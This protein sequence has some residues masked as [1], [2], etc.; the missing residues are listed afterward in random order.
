MD[1]KNTNIPQTP[2]AADSTPDEDIG[3]FLDSV[4][5]E[6]SADDFLNQLYAD[7]FKDLTSDFDSLLKEYQSIDPDDLTGQHPASEEKAEPVQE[8][9]DIYSY[10]DR[11]EAETHRKFSESVQQAMEAEQAEAER[12]EAQAD[13][14]NLSIDML[15]DSQADFAQAVEQA[16]A[17]EQ[18]QHTQIYSAGA[19][20]EAAKDKPQQGRPQQSRPQQGRPQQN[21]P[22]QNRPQQGKPQNGKKPAKANAQKQKKNG[23]KRSLFPQKNDSTFEIFRKV[24]FLV[25]LVVVVVCIGIIGNTYLLQPY[26]EKGRA[27]RI[28]DLLK[29]DD[30]SDEASFRAAYGNTSLPTGMRYDLAKFYAENNDFYGYLEIPGTGVSTPVVQGKD[31][32]EYLRKNFFGETTKYGCPF[33]NV[34]NTYAALDDNTSIFGHNMEYDDLVF[35]ELEKYREIEGF[36]KA[37]V[38]HLETMYADYTFKIY[39]VFLS[40]SAGDS[41]GW[42]FDYIFTQLKDDAERK[43]YIAELDQ[44]KLYSTGVDIL[45]T[46]KL[47]TLSTCA[48]DF[49]TERL[50]VVGRLV[51]EGE[52]ATV[53]VSKAVKNNNPRFPDKYYQRKGIAN[54]YANAPKWIPNA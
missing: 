2:D 35:G 37:P 46:D 20:R 3:A 23:S 53:D 28:S 48:Y 19:V 18:A 32:K 10:S 11:E 15:D 5:G 51:R 30:V 22:Q 7:S 38:I 41:T 29:N 24:L 50:V 8:M 16:A 54:P 33:L 1:E 6:G 47:L 26:L 27:G 25:S 40:D 45:P 14:F 13:A 36:R 12:A 34:K 9:E 39:A 17:P 4:S 52:L 31:N 43:E 49:S 42:F 44:R 21:R